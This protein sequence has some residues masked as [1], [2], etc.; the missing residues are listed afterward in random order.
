LCGFT[1]V[2]AGR[3]VFFLTILLSSTI[4]TL[5]ATIFHLITPQTSQRRFLV[6]LL[7]LRKKNRN[8]RRKKIKKNERERIEPENK[9]KKKGTC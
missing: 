4:P 5:A 1:S 9:Q 7:R 6:F 8:K 2:V 3:I